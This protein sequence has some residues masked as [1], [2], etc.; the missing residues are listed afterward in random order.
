MAHFQLHD[1]VNNG[2]TLCTTPFLQDPDMPVWNECD[3]DDDDALNSKTTFPYIASTKELG[4][5]QMWICEVRNKTHPLPYFSS[6]TIDLTELLQCVEDGKQTRCTLT[7]ESTFPFTGDYVTPIWTAGPIEVIPPSENEAPDTPWN[8]TPCIGPSFSYPNWDVQDFAY[9]QVYGDESSVSFRLN[10][11]GNNQS[12]TCA[13]SEGD[14]MRCDN[15]T[16][17]RFTGE[18]R[19]LSISQTWVCRAEERNSE[20][21]TFRAV[22]SSIIDFESVNSTYILGS[23]TEPIELTPKVAPE[24]VNHPGCIEVSETP[25]WEVTSWVWNEKWQGEYNSGNLTVTFRNSA[26]GFSLECT[27]DGEELNRDGRYGNERWWGSTVA[28]QWRIGWMSDSL[29]TSPTFADNFETTALFK[30]I[31]MALD[32]FQG[33]RY[34]DISITPFLH[35]SDPGRWHDC[36]NYETGEETSN[37]WTRRSLDC[38]WQLDLA[39]GYFAINHT[40]FCNDKDPDN[41]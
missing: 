9:R 7:D 3:D 41:P 8:P 40:W 33:V 29:Y 28:T 26:N 34:K 22:G 19:E 30:I 11:H 1:V 15:S 27:G 2:T 35:T 13:I 31:F 37:T 14:W 24:G 16:D 23:L 18:I 32:G 12:T 5:N 39:T 20:N 36:K 6:A 25:S 4:I 38:K 10:N 17:V 21:V